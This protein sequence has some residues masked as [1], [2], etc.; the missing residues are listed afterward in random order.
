MNQ[1]VAATMDAGAPDVVTADAGNTVDVVTPADVARDSGPADAGMDVAM[2]VGVDAG[3]AT[4]TDD[5][6]C[7]CSTVGARGR[8]GGVPWAMLAVLASALGAARR[9]RTARA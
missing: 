7:G 9:K 6:G 5:G 8:V 4:G 3:T 1:C 2:D